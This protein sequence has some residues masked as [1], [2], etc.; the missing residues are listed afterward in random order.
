MSSSVRQFEA[1]DPFGRTWSVEFLWQQNAISIRHA[2][3]IDCKFTLRDGAVKEERVVALP[4]P[5]LNALA[6]RLGRK[7][8]DA[9][10]M[11]L[12]AAHLR[13]LIETGE[14]LEKALVTA[15]AADL[16]KANQ[17]VDSARVAAAV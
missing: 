8:N 5:L 2:D 11:K 1:T 13:T 16:D 10:V 4:H 3:T 9:W 12:A 15:T 17:S 7:L 6:A 14:D